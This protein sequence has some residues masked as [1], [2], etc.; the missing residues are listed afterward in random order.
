MQ[1]YTTFRYVTP[2]RCKARLP[3]IPEE[4]DRLQKKGWWAQCKWNGTNSL[5]F[6][7]PTKDVQGWNR[8][9]SPH[10]AWS[11]SK[12]NTELYRSLPGTSWWVFN[13]ELLHSK[14]PSVKDVHFIHDVLVADGFLL[15]GKTYAQRYEI[16]YDL[17]S[18]RA[19]GTIDALDHWVIDKHT[20]LAKSYDTDFIGLYAK[21][22][23][24]LH[25]G[26]ICKDPR[27]VL[28][29]TELG[30]SGRA[31]WMMKLRRP[32]RAKAIGF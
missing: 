17:W 3:P 4:L 8:H 19:D 25:E 12:Q 22:D 11:P 16:L 26:L 31:H 6:V 18:P 27:A 28:S 7:S 30:P 32:D 23:G 15:T 14:G 24:P 9:N 29:V 20:W 13:G 21:L 2:P 5:I 10:K 1:P